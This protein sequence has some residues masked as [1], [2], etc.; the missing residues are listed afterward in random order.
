MTLAGL[1]LASSLSGRPEPELLAQA[2]DG[3]LPASRGVNGGL[4]FDPAD[5]VS[6]P[7]RTTCVVKGCGRHQRRPPV[8]LGLCQTHYKRYLKGTDLTDR[9]HV[10]KARGAAYVPRD[11]SREPMRP[12][13]RPE[14]AE[15]L[16]DLVGNPS[17][18][19][20]CTGGIR[21]V[22]MWDHEDR[23][24]EQLGDPEMWQ[25][26]ADEALERAWLDLMSGDFERRLAGRLAALRLP[27]PKT[28]QSPLL[29]SAHCR[30]KAA[31][32]QAS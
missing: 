20:A 7:R 2:I 18:G 29:A 19:V 16:W 10:E 30:A 26:V 21:R 3:V 8:R 23:Q 28:I 24:A 17:E 12:V 27:K 11:A 4:Y 22:A 14:E 25:A 5:L 32:R 9:I 6:L 13:L 31:E 1:A 15:T